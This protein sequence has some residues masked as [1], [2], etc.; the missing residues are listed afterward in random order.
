MVLWPVPRAAHI[1]ASVHTVEG[2]VQ[3]SQ[4]RRLDS[5]SL[6]SS[7]TARRSGRQTGYPRFGY[8]RR[9]LALSY[10]TKS[11]EDGP[12]KDVVRH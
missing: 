7:N 6:P 11:K 12:A 3:V 9:P 2:D 1:R 4:P 5:R 10:V 8:A